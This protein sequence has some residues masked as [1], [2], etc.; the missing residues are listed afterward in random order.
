M[1]TCD[2]CEGE[3]K[4]AFSCCGDVIYKDTE[5]CPSCKE[6]VG[7]E[8]EFCECHFGE[9]LKCHQESIDA[10]YSQEQRQQEAEAWEE[11]NNHP[12]Y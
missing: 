10:E 11:Y 2:L 7:Y 4:V 6:H 3:G 1:E 12:H 8:E 5:L 9:S